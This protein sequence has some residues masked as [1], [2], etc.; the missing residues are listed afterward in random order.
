MSKAVAEANEKAAV[1]LFAV[2]SRLAAKRNTSK[3]RAKESKQ[4][5]KNSAG[6]KVCTGTTV[7][8]KIKI[9]HF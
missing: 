8:S 3:I 9:T 2:A 5:F 7:Y 6:L 1:A 4:F